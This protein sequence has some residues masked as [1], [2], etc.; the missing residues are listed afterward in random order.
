MKIAPDASL[1][2][3]YL[4]IFLTHKKGRLD[5]IRYLS[6]IISGTVTDLKDISYF[7]TASIGIEGDSHIQID[8]DYAGKTPAKIDV[9]KNALKL[10]VPA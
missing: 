10:I 3:P 1:A 9:A 6:A 2:S 4:Y 8:G 5:L 7:R